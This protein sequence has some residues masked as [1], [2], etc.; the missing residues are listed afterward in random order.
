MDTP[1][2]GDKLNEERAFVKRY[3]EGLADTKVEY[4]ADYSAPLED[5]PRKVATV[6]VPVAEPPTLM[7]VDSGPSHDTITLTVKSLKPSL[8]VNV[9]AQTT[10]TISDLKSLVCKAAPTAPPPDQ[11]RLLLKGKALVDTKL[12]KEYDIQDG[13]VV[14]LLLKPAG[15][16]PPTLT[17]TTSMA[18]DSSP[19]TSRPL[20]VS[21]APPL[22]PQ[23]EVSS[24]TFH[25]TVSDPTFWQKIHALCVSEFAYEDEGDACWELFLLSVKGKLSAGEAAKIRDVV[26]VRG[27]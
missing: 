12:L 20:Q 10:D 27:E 23:A 22:G 13:A 18:D 26:G 24:S 2:S 3:T 16:P 6:N 25:R 17:I 8:S 4:P 19:G 1:L 15:P 11:Q 21:D 7:E 5:R 14:H 9:K